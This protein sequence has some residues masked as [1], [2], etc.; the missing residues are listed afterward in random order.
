[1]RD[2]LLELAA[3]AATSIVVS[4]L[5]SYV[6]KLD[7]KFR[8]TTPKK[9]WLCRVRQLFTWLC[10]IT[11]WFVPTLWFVGYDA[12]AITLLV[13]VAAILQSFFLPPAYYFDDAK[14]LL[15]TL[16]K[17][18]AEIHLQDVLMF[19][20]SS[21]RDLRK[22]VPRL[23]ELKFADRVVMQSP[24]LNK[25]GE[26]RD[27]VLLRKVLGEVHITSEQVPIASELLSKIALAIKFVRSGRDWRSAFFWHKITISRYD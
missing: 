15:F 9:L 11:I 23:L 19:G 22:V 14:S 5:V 18:G 3:L 20:K 2:F 7:F 8:V 4:M 16:S 1:M 26:P 25:S 13:L 24:L 27:T 21:Y 17:E 10:Y 12:T 6:L